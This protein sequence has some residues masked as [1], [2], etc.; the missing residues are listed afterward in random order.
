MAVYGKQ[1]VDRGE[2]FFKAWQMVTE[3]RLFEEDRNT[4]RQGEADIHKSNQVSNCVKKYSNLLQPAEKIIIFFFP[5][6]GFY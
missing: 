1:R 4:V 3:G 2:V 6:Y 5:I